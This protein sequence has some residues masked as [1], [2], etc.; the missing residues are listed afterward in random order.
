MAPEK[1]IEIQMAAV[2]AQEA[3]SAINQ[4]TEAVKG[5]STATDDQA[6]A[7]AAA[8]TEENQGRQIN[9]ERAKVLKDVADKTAM[10]G[11]AIR[12][13]AED[14]R[15]SDPATAQTLETMANGLEQVGG[16][17]AYASQGFA[18]AGP[19]GAAVGAALAVASTQVTAL[20][21][22]YV[23]L[24]NGMK[25][26]KDS[27]Q[28]LAE[29]EESHA[30]HHEEMVSRQKAA[31]FKE[32]LEDQTEAARKLSLELAALEK[33]EAATARLDTAK[34]NREDQAR[35]EAG[36]D[37]ETVR[38]DRALWDEEQ[39]KQRIESSLARKKSAMQSAIQI[40]ETAENDATAAE[41]AVGLDP[42]KVK[43]RREKATAAKRAADDAARE[44]DDASNLAG[45]DKA[46]IE[47]TTAAK[48]EKE[49]SALRNRKQREA[50]A[51]NRKDMTS[52]L[53][54]EEQEAR[55]GL[56]AASDD[57]SRK[58]AI[59]AGRA[60][61][62]TVGTALDKISNSLDDG[63][64]SKE[65]EKLQQQFS[66]A[67]AGMGGATVSALAKMLAEMEAQAKKIEEIDKRTKSRPIGL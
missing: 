63:T 50:E 15:E 27:F 23:D 8:A 41:S 1:R 33:V 61:N 42:E 55:G 12:K 40:A 14:F 26:R 52:M 25:E 20:Y 67:T 54:N 34:K 36:E 59:A 21:D 10:V 31:G 35:I 51:Q 66:K 38:A 53:A 62:K 7:T 49:K 24:M 11:E 4:S 30:S 9:I 22:A 47:E 48:V 37:P 17:A 43:A 6:K 18:I 57:A 64:N 19:A 65:I 39:A 58:F 13:S 46:T 16:M 44:Y 60:P 3:A 28:T 32:L 2:G 29:A 45:I 5:L 56:D